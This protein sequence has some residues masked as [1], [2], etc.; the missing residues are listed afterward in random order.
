MNNLPDFN[1]KNIVILD[2]LESVASLKHP[3]LDDFMDYPKIPSYKNLEMR[4]TQKMCGTNGQIY[5]FERLSDRFLD[6][7]C[8]NRTRWITPEND[9]YGFAKFVYAHK[10]SFIELLGKGR[11]FGEWTG[12]KINSGEGLSQRMFLL[13][14][15]YY[16]TLTL[17]PSTSCVPELYR[18][19]ISLVTIN[20]I[21]KNLK[22]NG[23]YFVPNFMRP[24]GIV[25]ELFFNERVFAKFKKVFFPEETQWRKRKKEKK[26]RLPSDI[27]IEYLLQPIR[28][29]KILS[30]DE[31]Y[32]KNYPYSLS[33]IGAAYWQDL[34]DEQQIDVLSISHEKFKEIKREFGRKFF[35]FVKARISA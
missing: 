19:E 15:S 26:I 17:P 23:S 1:N 25:V 12:P 27:D 4:V 32:T 16:Q 10:D 30:R 2:E 3:E 9:N 35:K 7:K 8:G 29:D 13:F 14:A 31:S 21:M 18:G 34:L 20:K 6:L 24:E 33:S 11:H 28:L 22:E 5:I